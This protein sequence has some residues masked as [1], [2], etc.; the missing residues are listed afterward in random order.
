MSS[1]TVREFIA[2]QLAPH[3]PATW[4]VEPGVPT[5]GTLSKPVLWI[6]YTAFEPLPA[7]PVSKLQVSADLC[8]VTSK[9]D[10]RKGETEADELVADL[11][12]AVWQAHPFYSITATKTVFLDA[13]FGWRLSINVITTNPEEE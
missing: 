3:L 11:Y 12:A 5:L 1:E 7:A 8:I 4:K 6:E 10:L 13:Y 2:A 9:T